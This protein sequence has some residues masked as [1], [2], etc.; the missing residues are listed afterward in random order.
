[1]PTSKAP[2][3]PTR[4]QRVKI[5]QRTQSPKSANATERAYIELKRCVQTNTLKAGSTHLQQDIAQKLGLSRTP[6]REAIIRLD[7]E[8][9]VEI[10]PRHGILI[11]PLSLLEIHEICETLSALEALAAERMARDGTSASHLQQLETTHVG[12][13]RALDDGNINLW[14]RHDEDFHGIIVRSAGNG[15]LTRLAQHF[16]DRLKRLRTRTAKL[17]EQPT[18]SNREHAAL[19]AAI[20]RQQPERAYELQ[21]Q[22]L[23]RFASAMSALFGQH[24]LTEI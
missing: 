22:H 10:R 11:R 20:R 9:F 23:L 7:S 19:I 16:W 12:M 3:L 4:G 17:R 13:Q 5:T 2:G 8:R 24:G 6:A 14:I 21:R 18:K 1:M 15:E